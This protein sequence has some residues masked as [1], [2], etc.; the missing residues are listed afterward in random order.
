MQCTLPNVATHEC[1][2]GRCQVA[3][4][5][6]TEGFSDCNDDPS[7]GCEIDITTNSACGSCQNTCYPDYE[8]CS[9]GLCVR[10][11]FARGTLITLADGSSKPVEDITYA[12][13]LATWDFDAGRLT[14]AWP[15]WI[16][17][18]Q[19]GSNY[20]R[21]TFSDGT[22]LSLVGGHRVMNIGARAFTKANTDDTPIGTR[23]RMLKGGSAGEAVLVRKELIV[24]AVENYNII[25]GGG[26]M[27]VFANGVL[28]S[29]YF[30]NIRR[31]DPAGL[32]FVKAEASAP[33]SFINTT[34]FVEA[35][36]PARFL[37]CLRLEEQ[38]ISAR[39]AQRILD[40]IIPRVTLDIGG[41]EGRELDC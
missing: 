5:G 33:S 25:A 41:W 31:F 14:S 35:G 6:C 21:L 27:N 2:A 10:R 39:S 1:I 8:F 26:H 28:T 15:L 9:N 12:D 20:T 36:V 3:S 22:S 11:C 19:V 37:K 16:K 23:T 32:R 30:N 18:P 34:G 7:D 40:D 24:E 38:P 29:T 13:E 17:R 4:S